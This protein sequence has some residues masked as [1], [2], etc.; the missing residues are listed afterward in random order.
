MNIKEVKKRLEEVEKLLD[1]TDF[2]EKLNC[3]WF[4]DIIDKRNYKGGYLCSNRYLG[5]KEGI[6]FS[7]KCPFFASGLCIQSEVRFEIIRVL[8]K[9]KKS[10]GGN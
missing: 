8:N 3:S 9:L 2:C 5:N 1:I 4:K 7:K 6:E 10:K